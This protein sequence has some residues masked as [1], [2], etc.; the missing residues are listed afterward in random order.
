M[1]SKCWDHKK[2]NGDY[3]LKND[4]PICL[5]DRLSIVS[6]KMGLNPKELIDTSLDNVRTLE[7]FKLLHPTYSVLSTLFTLIITAISKN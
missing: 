2:T 6:K 3:V 7:I 1:A 5:A 4:C